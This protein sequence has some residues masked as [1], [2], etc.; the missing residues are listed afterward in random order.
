VAQALAAVHAAGLV[1]RDVKP[2]NI[3][4]RA[5]GA[6][7]VTDFGMAATLVDLLAERR[8]TPPNVLLGTADY[9]SP[10]AISGEVVDG[11]ADLYSLG[12]VLYEMLTG[13]VPFAGRDPYET[14]RAHCEERVPPLP[15]EIPT[16]VRAIVECALQKRREDRFTTAGEMADA[17][18]A[19]E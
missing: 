16:A 6:P 13:F 5:D 19:L 12:V 7:V 3:L 15:G 9:L 18:A 8:L 1:H 2:S 4:L 14:M 10:E 17:L 11:R